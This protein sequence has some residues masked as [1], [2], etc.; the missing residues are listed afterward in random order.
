MGRSLSFKTFLLEYCQYLTGLYN[1]KSLLKFSQKLDEEPRAEEPVLL[2]AL[3]NKRDL[4]KFK[5]NLNFVLRDKMKILESEYKKYN[6]LELMFKKSENLSVDLKKVY[7]A[8]ISQKNKTSANNPL[9]DS[10][11]NYFLN[12]MKETKLTNYRLCSDLKLNLSN[13]TY[14][15][16]GQNEKLSLENCQKVYNYLN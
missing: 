8:Y 1:T 9:K 3:G 5:K 16:K 6:N 14:F 4:Q 12:K 11:R 13:F 15:L 10:Y 7:E 2:Y